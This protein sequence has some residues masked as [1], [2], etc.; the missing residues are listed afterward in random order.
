MFSKQFYLQGRCQRGLSCRFS[1]DLN[2]AKR[3]SKAYSKVSSE[4]SHVEN[5]V[6]YA[7]ADLSAFQISSIAAAVAAT[8][9]A[10]SHIQEYY[11][12]Q[13]EQ[14]GQSAEWILDVM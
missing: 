5:G 11:E 13:Q 2:F 14:K 12:W 6:D 1:H 4:I 7:A 8:A 9:R 3:V 10:Q